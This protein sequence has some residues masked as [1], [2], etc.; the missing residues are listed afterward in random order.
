MVIANLET[1]KEI[2]GFNEI[3]PTALTAFDACGWC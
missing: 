2:T 1:A 3:V